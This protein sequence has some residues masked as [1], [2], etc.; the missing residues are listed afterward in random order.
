MS[1][2]LLTFSVCLNLV[3]LG[4]TGYWAASIHSGGNIPLALPAT[5]RQT[6]TSAVPA[7]ANVAIEAT[8]TPLRWNEL[9]SE[10]YAIYIT[11]LR[12]AGCPEPVLRRI[13]SADLKELY[14]R[15]AFALVKEFHR[16]FWE[17][18]AR[19]NVRYYYDTTLAQRVKAL[20]EEPDPL[21][22]E[23]VGGSIAE[24]SRASAGSS[25]VTHFIDFL[26]AAKQQQLRALTER[27][28]VQQEAVRQADLSPQE[29]KS[30]LAQLRLEMESEQAQILLPEE[31]AEYQLRRS[32]AA[33]ELRA[34]CGV[35]FSE[36]E[37]R[38]LTKT[39]NDYHHRI[40][41]QAEPDT[42]TLDEKLESVLGPARFTDFSRA[43]ST[44]YRE[45]YEVVTDFGRPTETAA[46]IFEMRLASEKQSDQIRADKNRPPEEK[47]ALLDELE[48][49]VEQGVRTRLGAEAYQSYKARGGLWINSLG[50]F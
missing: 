46:E 26:S 25:L 48:E 41:S 35:D 20:C 29:E 39:L 44:G 11:N 7:P 27:Y 15:K 32:T 43:R 19:E 2:R 31:L 22:K 6:E 50:R 14:A 5:N 24:L 45:I 21:L 40:A 8:A 38:N 36:T 30:R 13:I 16:D 4:A 47:Q 12:K 23:L 1:S 42:Q 28:E 10:D 33:C 17:I 49:Q 9:E 37:L 18:A 3:L 34:L